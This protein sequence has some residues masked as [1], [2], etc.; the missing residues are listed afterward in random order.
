[1]DIAI[2]DRGRPAGPMN[3]GG[4][5]RHGRLHPAGGRKTT[6]TAT[7][8]ICS[9]FHMAANPIQTHDMLMSKWRLIMDQTYFE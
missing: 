8:L 1:M 2:F 9:C 5:L 4:E 6:P 3:H 7:V